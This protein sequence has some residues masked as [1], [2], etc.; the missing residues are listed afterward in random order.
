MADFTLKT[1]GTAT[2][3]LDGTGNYSTPSATAGVSDIN[4]CTGSVSFTGSGVSQS[5]NTFTFSCAGGVTLATSDV[6]YNVPTDYATIDLAQQA[7]NVLMPAPAI[8][9][10]ITI[11]G[12]QTAV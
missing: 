9:R 2:E 7:L 6:T 1:T 4:A 11:T 5:G 12:H 8:T 10:N 3:Y